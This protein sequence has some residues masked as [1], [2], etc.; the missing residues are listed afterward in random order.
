MRRRPQNNICWAYDYGIL[1][2]ETKATDQKIESYHH[3][4]ANRVYSSGKKMARGQVELA[5]P[6]ETGTPVVVV[7]PYGE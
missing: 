5:H 7:T 4:G 2:C 6:A 1:T 3:T